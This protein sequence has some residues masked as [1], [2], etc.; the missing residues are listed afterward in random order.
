MLNILR[1]G[2]AR[3]TYF[4]QY[5]FGR[6]GR[7]LA[8]GLALVPGQEDPRTQVMG[9]T[10]SLNIPEPVRDS[11]RYYLYRL[12]L[13]RV[14]KLGGLTGYAHANTGNFSVNRDMALNVP[15]GLVDFAEIC[16][17]G[18]LNWDLYY[19]FL[20][21][22]FRLTAAGGSD[23]PWGGTIGDS[24]IYVYTGRRFDA[25]EWFAAF[26]AG[27]TFVTTGP[28]LEFTVDGRPPGEVLKA[29]RGQNLHIRARMTAGW[30]PASPGPLE[31]VVN[32]E[33]SRAMQPVDKS[34]TLEFDIPAETS[35]WIAARTAAGVRTTGAHTTPVYVSVNGERHWKRDAV[36]ALL[37]KR[38][39]DLDEIE[40]LLAGEGPAIPDG[41]RG[42]WEN[43][44]SF[45]QARNELRAMV[46]EARQEYG[47]LRSQF[48]A[49]R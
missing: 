46:A 15:R 1:M 44:E 11:G 7:F 2:D 39:Q 3:E 9:H 30:L 17:F 24:R 25:D 4:E 19:E 23:A 8:D 49:G 38:G 20:N 42:S 31:I 48:E 36:Q 13:D 43:A 12:I 29:S 33:V 47:G 14:R 6:R 22:G 45:R 26:R 35:M 27:R 18:H 41:A 21:L 40:R 5:A 28:M 16:E 37:A 10:I 34:A 32:G